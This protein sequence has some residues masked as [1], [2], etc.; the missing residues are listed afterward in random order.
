[1]L[2]VAPKTSLFDRLDLKTKWDYLMKKNHCMRW[3][4]PVL[5]SPNVMHLS[6]LISDSGWRHVIVSAPPEVRFSSMWP[7][8]TIAL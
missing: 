4:I 1:M 2:K 6:A 7:I 8:S 5:Y 3:R